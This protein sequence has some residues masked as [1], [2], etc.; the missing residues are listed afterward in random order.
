MH[1]KRGKRTARR[2]RRA[3]NRRF[4]AI[5][6]LAAIA[7][8][9]LTA[10]MWKTLTRLPGEGVAVPAYV[11]Q[12]FLTENRWSR[13]GIKLKKVRGVVIHYVGNPGT[14]A[15][16]NRDYFQSLASGTDGVYA[17]AH[18]VVGLEGEVVQCI[19]LT[20]I[21]Y[22]SNSR[23]ADTISVEVCHPG[24]DG[25]FSPATYRRVV[26]LTAWL[27]QKFHLTAENVIRH[28]DVT[29]KICPKYYVDH[30]Q[31]WKQFREDVKQKISGGL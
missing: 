28:Y 26:E 5:C 8:L 18:F 31:A 11:R 23:N 20:E 15:Q 13:P 3:G 2:T 17:S 4:T 1:T 30:P 16:A 12:D 7:A 22:A 24:A 27:C 29:G 9:G 25:K 19:P 21:S 14:T 6:V 10:W